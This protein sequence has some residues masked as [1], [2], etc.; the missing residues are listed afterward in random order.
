MPLSAQKVEIDFDGGLDTGTDSK[1]VQ[2]GNFLALE[3]AVRKK[4]KRLQPRFGTSSLTR[5]ISSGSSQITS[6]SGLAT[7]NDELIEFSNNSLFTRNESKQEWINRGSITSLVV[8]HSQI[9]RNTYQ[10]TQVQGC[11][12]QGLTVFAWKDSRGGVRASVIDEDTGAVIQNDTVISSSGDRPK[13]HCIGNTIWVFYNE[14]SNLKGQSVTIG[15]PNTFTT[16][17]TLK[18]D[19]K[20]AEP[21]FDVVSFGSRMVMAYHK[22]DSTIHVF[23]MNEQ[24]TVTPSGSPAE[25]TIAERAERCLT[26]VNQDDTNIFVGWQNSTSGVRC[27]GFDAV[28]NALFAISTL[29]ADTAQY[30]NIC[31]I[32]TA[33]N[34]VRFFYE[35]NSAQT[36][37]QLIKHNTVTTAG[38][39]GTTAVFKRSVGLASKP[40]TVSGVNYVWAAHDATQQACFFLLNE[41]S[42]V[43]AQTLYGRGGGLIGTP[44]LPAVGA[45]SDG[46]YIF[47]CAVKNKIETENNVTFSTKGANRTNVNF[48]DLSSYNNVVL[49]D[50][51]FIIGGSPQ[52]YDSTQIVEAGFHVYPENVSIAQSGAAGVANGTYG[53]AVI[54]EW[55][56]SKGQIHRSA[57][58]FQN[59]T[60]TGGPRN[61]TLTIPTLRVTKKSNVVIHV[62]RTEASGAI[63]YRLTSVSSPTFNDT[64]V[65]TVSYVDTAVDSAIT[66]NQILYTQGGIL[67]NI[68][69]SPCSF[70]TVHR[71][72]IFIKTDLPNILQYTKEWRSFEA[73]NFNDLLIKTVDPYGGDITATASL[74]DKFIIFKRTSIRV[75]TGQGPTDAGTLDDFTQDELVTTDIGCTEPNSVVQ[76]PEGLLFKGD[77]GIYLLS[78]GLD[79]S[80]IGKPVEDYNDYEIT[81]SVLLEGTNRVIFT[82]ANG[83]ALV[84][85]YYFKQ[86]SIFTN[87]DAQD[88][89]NYQGVYHFLKADGTVRKEVEDSFE[90]AG[91]QVPFN[92][93]TAWIKFDGMQGY[94]RVLMV[95]VLGNY[96]SAHTL[97]MDLS[98]DYEDAITETVTW[99]PSTALNTSTW[100]SDAT[101]G[102]AG[103]V[104]GGSGET[105]YQIRHKPRRQKCQAMKIGISGLQSSP[106]GEGFQLSGL[107]L[108]VGV[109]GGGN[110]L[111]QEKTI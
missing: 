16:A 59:F 6:G 43:V 64:T 77:K 51:L 100:G 22:S 15:S 17:T 89:V 88:A 42:N 11:T 63:Y 26:I 1:A 54:Y 104:W 3:N 48:V 27:R 13:V 19:L 37:N 61:V 40:F 75:F 2:N 70:A 66:A 65:D 29:D 49:G 20:A 71:N 36:Y 99:N 25:L 38:S 5:S 56:D 35:K 91:A 33:T 73:V 34:Q 30:D 57:P 23:Y 81:S 10:Q 69:P 50:N 7:F 86:W 62:Y 21:F 105:T 111:R 102:E 80:Y 28:F 67:D 94:Q 79:V 108:T 31:G 45:N 107:A 109:Y 110:R 76:I 68:V 84:Y 18:S 83:P 106:Y 32:K 92:I 39:L 93:D 14:T 47:P 4:Y 9:L 52:I 60:V 41:S 82:S 53:Y 8:S 72:R 78:R 96:R 97:K 58:S 44:N 12:L 24:G 103:T 101:W 90:D 95:H 87:Y 74:D 55:I 46:D 98:Y 85:D